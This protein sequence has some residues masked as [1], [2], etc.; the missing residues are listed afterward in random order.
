MQ[1]NGSRAVTAVTLTG[2]ADTF[3]YNESK[4]PVLVISNPTAGALSPVIDGDG[5]TTVALR[6]VGDVDVSGG[7][8]V[9]SIAADAVVAIPLNSIKEYL[10]G[11]I[12]ISTG[13]GLVCQ[14]LEF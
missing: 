10:K 2:T 3:T 4:N 9:G 6:G 1:G 11:T 8:A 13:T 5:A 7:Y 12:A 14:L